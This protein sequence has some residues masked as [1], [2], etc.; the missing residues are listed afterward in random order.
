MT[1]PIPMP[2]DGKDVPHIVIEVNQACNLTCKA[3][4][5]HKHG[6]TKPIDQILEEI[7]YAVS[8]RNL[9][10]ITF[11][12]GEPTLHPELPRAI[13]HATERGIKTS[14]LTNG[15]LLSDERLAT[16]E[17]AGLARVALHVDTH[18]QRPDA[19]PAEREADLDVVREAIFERVARHGILCGVVATLYQSNLRDLPALVDFTLRNR[20]ASLALIT[21]CKDFREVAKAHAVEG[22]PDFDEHAVLADE[23][24]TCEEVGEIMDR[25]FGERPI[26]YIASSH[27]D[28]EKRWL[29]YLGFA[30]TDRDGGYRTLFLSSRYRRTIHLANWLQ[31]AT[32]GRYKFDMVPGAA[33]SVLVCW[34]Y[35]LLGAEVG[36]LFSSLGFLSGLLRPGTRIHSKVFVFQQPPNVT[37]DGEIEI[38]KDCPDATV[39]NGEIMPLCVAD[40]LSP[41][42]MD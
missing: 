19:E 15:V 40:I 29:F 13:A 25:E 24:V 4:Y 22:G 7:D 3:C 26:H 9:D 38:C 32:K 5:K 20:H 33:E 6:Y 17:Q 21:L 41:Q 35:G 16:Y 11:A 37:A 34:L 23:E 31:K 18:Q 27:S 14:I 28:A 10:M 1:E 12:G 8:Q 30:I 42:G 36:N 39:R 2:F